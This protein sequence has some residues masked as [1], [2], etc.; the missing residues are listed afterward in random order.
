MLGEVLAYLTGTIVLV[1]FIAVS[2]V[3]K[4]KVPK[5][6]FRINL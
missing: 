3:R 6:T 5:I 2:I 1:D 4:I